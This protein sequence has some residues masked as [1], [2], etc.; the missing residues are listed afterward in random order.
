MPLATQFGDVK[1]KRHG[2]TGLFIHSL[3]ELWPVGTGVKAFGQDRTN[4]HHTK[5]PFLV[6]PSAENRRFLKN[7]NVVF[8]AAAERLLFHHALILL[9]NWLFVHMVKLSNGKPTVAALLLFA[10]EPQAA[11]PKRSGLKIYRYRTADAEGSRETLDFDPISIEGNIY[12]QIKN[13]VSEASRTI[14]SKY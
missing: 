3:L 1:R 5:P 8:C 9:E 14:E 13:A 10:E 2:L 11:L 7:G 12:D 4:I 6:M